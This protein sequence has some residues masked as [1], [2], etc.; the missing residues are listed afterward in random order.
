MSEH[1]QKIIESI[2]AEKAALVAAEEALATF[3]ATPILPAEAADATRM[4]RDLKRAVSSRESLVARFEQSL[5]DAEFGERL[6][7]DYLYDGADEKQREAVFDYAWRESH[8][9]GYSQ[10]EDTY[11]EIAALVNAAFEAGQAKG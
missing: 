3:E 4:L 1:K 2:A 9:S 5:R 11:E 10:V 7:A 6:A 8:S